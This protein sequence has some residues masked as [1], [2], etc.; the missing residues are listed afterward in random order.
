M[1]TCQGELCSTILKPMLTWFA[2]SVL[3]ML[4]EQYLPTKGRY[5]IMFIIKTYHALIFS[6]IC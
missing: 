5:P 4:M 6:D 1:S 2:V 3:A